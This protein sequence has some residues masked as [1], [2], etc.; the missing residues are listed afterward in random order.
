MIIEETIE[1]E[2]LKKETIKPL[3]IED[4]IKSRG[5]EP[6]RYSILSKNGNIYKIGVSGIK[7]SENTN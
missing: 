4:F 1:F 3:E 6:V 7:I 2:Y 5:I